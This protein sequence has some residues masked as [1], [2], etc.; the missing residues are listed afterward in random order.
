LKQTICR[1]LIFIFKFIYLNLL[2]QN[3]IQLSHLIFNILVILLYNILINNNAS[4]FN[5]IILLIFTLNLVLVRKFVLYYNPQITKARKY[6]NINIT[7]INYFNYFNYKNYIYKSNITLNSGLSMLVGISEAI[8]L[9]F[10]NMNLLY[11]YK[12]IFYYSLCNIKINSLKVLK[13]LSKNFS[14]LPNKINKDTK[15]NQWLA[16]LIDGNGCFKLTKKGYASLDIVMEIRDK[17]C[18]YLI[19]QKFGGSIKL[20]SGI[21]WLRYRLHH[22]KGLLDLINAINGEIRNPVRIIQFNKIC[23]NY[24]ISLIQPIPL[25]YNNGWFSGFFD[26][27]GSVY[28]NLNLN[29]LSSQIL[30][31]ASQK[32]NFILEMLVEL[33]GGTIYIKKEN[34][35]WIVFKKAEIN[36]LL[37]Y[38]ILFPSRSSKHNRL[39]LIS[40][41]FE[42]KE[43]KAHLASD[44]S[45]LGKTWKKFLFKWSNFEK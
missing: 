37:N 19:K 43:L 13:I 32:N 28:L 27:E 16:G 11:F 41:Y 44:N 2:K 40:K 6:S 3:T 12:F 30:I 4:I 31:T 34:F 15:F 1:E 9:L 18:L 7:N 23:L 38:F 25:T 39:K 33:Y 26:S 20:R 36:Q 35:E 17:H 8:C 22:K 45:I 29:L 42:L 14:I 10:F 24:K 5:N 21:K